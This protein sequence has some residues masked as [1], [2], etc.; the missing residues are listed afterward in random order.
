MTCN[1][2]NVI[3]AAYVEG[4]SRCR[5][6]RNNIQ[7]NSNG[8]RCQLGPGG[9]A[10]NRNVEWFFDGTQN[11][12]FSLIA[13]CDETWM[14]VWTR[15]ADAIYQI[16]GTPFRTCAVGLYEFPSPSVSDRD[17]LIMRT[18]QDSRIHG[19]FPMQGNLSGEFFDE[20]TFRVAASM[21]SDTCVS[22]ARAA[23]GPNSVWIIDYVMT[24]ADHRK[25]GHGRAVLRALLGEGA[26]LG[27][28]AALVVAELT[29]FRFYESLGFNKAAVALTFNRQ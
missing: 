9:H 28:R 10:D 14:T 26:R 19:L 20:P 13:L 12:D 17:I 1:S 4:F 16:L 11:F 24:M 21:A 27:A 18:A 15:D 22:S 6:Y 2:F 23:M 25:R 29:A 7:Q 8:L 3:L 5:G